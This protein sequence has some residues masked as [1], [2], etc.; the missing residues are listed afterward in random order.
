VEFLSGLSQLYRH[1]KGTAGSL[2]GDFIAA[3]WTTAAASLLARS[4]D[5][6]NY[7]VKYGDGKGNWSKVTKATLPLKPNESAI[8]IRGIYARTVGGQLYVG[9]DGWVTTTTSPPSWAYLA[10]SQWNVTAGSFEPCDIGARGWWPTLNP[11]IASFWTHSATSATPTFSALL[12]PTGSN[13][14]TFYFFD[15]SGNRDFHNAVDATKPMDEAR[16]ATVDIESP[17]DTLGNNK[18][19]LVDRDGNLNQLIHPV[20]NGGLSFTTWSLCRTI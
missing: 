8:D 4:G 14:F 2:K 6:V 19:F 3:E 12:D 13:P 1:S 10:V 7:V 9:V 18:I 11:G 16:S 20:G 15:L 17:L 5:A